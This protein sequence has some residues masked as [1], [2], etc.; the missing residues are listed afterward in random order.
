MAK[1]RASLYT[2]KVSASSG[3]SLKRPSSVMK[4]RHMSATNGGVSIRYRSDIFLSAV[5]MAPKRDWPPTSSSICLPTT[6]ANSSISQ[7]TYCGVLETPAAKFFKIGVGAKR[8][9]WKTLASSSQ[10]LLSTWRI[11]AAQFS[12][13]PKSTLSMR[14]KSRKTTRPSS[15]NR[16]LPSWGSAWTKPVTRSCTTQASTAISTRRRRSCR[17]SSWGARLGYHCMA[18]TRARPGGAMSSGMQPGEVTKGRNAWRAA[19]SSQLA[20]SL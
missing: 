20:I 16:R 15:P 3:S 10:F 9:S 4:V 19:N 2:L 8:T 6:Q 12:M 1:G 18:R 7:G 11:P 17:L 5:A 13:T 14:P